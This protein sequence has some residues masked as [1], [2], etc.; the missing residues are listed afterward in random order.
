MT[1]GFR[2]S[3]VAARAEL[4]GMCWRAERQHWLRPRGKR[5]TACTR[6][7]WK[8]TGRAR[9][10]LARRSAAQR[11]SDTRACASHLDAPSHLHGERGQ[12]EGT[13]DK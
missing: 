11:I 1:L 5:A 2:L 10:T 4:R 13:R 3:V 9:G 12:A 8:H 7:K 6:P